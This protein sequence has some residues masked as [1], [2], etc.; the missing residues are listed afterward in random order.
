MKR[1]ER[2]GTEILTELLRI[3][4]KKTIDLDVSRYEKGK[5]VFIQQKG[6]DVS[7]GY[8]ELFYLLLYLHL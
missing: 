5:I 8:F 1:N 2:G 6:G 7:H 4:L 3:Y